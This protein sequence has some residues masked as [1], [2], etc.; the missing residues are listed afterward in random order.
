MRLNIQLLN[1]FID[2]N[3]LSAFR[4]YVYV[5]NKF[6]GHLHS[7]QF[8]T[9]SKELGISTRTIQQNLK[10]LKNLNICNFHVNYWRFNSWVKWVSTD[11]NR[12]FEI[13]IENLRNL[14]YIRSLFYSLKYKGAWRVSKQNAKEHAKGHVS[15]FAPVSATFV[16]CV[17]GV[18]ASVSTLLKHLNRSKVFKLLRVIKKRTVLGCSVTIEPLKFASKYVQVPSFIQKKGNFYKLL[19]FEPNLVNF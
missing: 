5:S 3:A 10:Q 19:T 9:I 13:S 2:K 7:N 4:L 18:K 15:S 11:K 6:N 8:K 1:H 17:T 14:K 16:Q 12:I